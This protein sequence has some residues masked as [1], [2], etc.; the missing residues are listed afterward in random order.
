MAEGGG[1]R[2]IS[3]LP[4]PVRAQRGLLALRPLLWIDGR[5]GENPRLRGFLHLGSIRRQGPDTHSLPESRGRVGAVC[6]CGPGRRSSHGHEGADPAPL[7]RRDEQR[8]DPAS[9][10]LVAKHATSR[11]AEREGRCLQPSQIGSPIRHRHPLIPGTVIGP[12]RN[13]HWP[14]ANPVPLG[15]ASA[16]GP[17]RR[18]GPG[19]LGA[20]EPIP[21]PV[22]PDHSRPGHI[23]RRQPPRRPGVDLPGAESEG[24]TLGGAEHLVTVAGVQIS[25][26]GATGT[27]EQ[28]FRPDRASQRTHAAPRQPPGIS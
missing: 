10:P 26:G 9:Q 20:G 12:Y 11:F 6:E 22:P 3:R 17:F 28:G 21:E 4:Y 19:T 1:V 14:T 23:R 5:G 8:C 18:C 15:A 2:P 7:L 13:R 27:G 16:P 24:P 25:G